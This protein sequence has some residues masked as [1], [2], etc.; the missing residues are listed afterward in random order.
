MLTGLSRPPAIACKS[1]SSASR[2]LPVGC[3]VFF[4]PHPAVRESPAA[5]LPAIQRVLPSP[6]ASA[7]DY[8]QPTFLA[9]RRSE[10]HT[11][12]LQSRLHLVCRLLLEKKKE[13]DGDTPDPVPPRTQANPTRSTR[14]GASV[15][16]PARVWCV[17]ASQWHCNV[18]HL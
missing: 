14:P 17:C 16:R 9:C 12:E 11:S 18:A 4:F 1:E 3:R 10:E 5:L 7:A 8:R 6:P 13:S 15:R 2:A